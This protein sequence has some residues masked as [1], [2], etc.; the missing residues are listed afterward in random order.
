MK[1]LIINEQHTQN[2]I[3]YNNFET[4]FEF[5]PQRSLPPACAIPQFPPKSTPH[6]LG[7]K[8]TQTVGL[9]VMKPTG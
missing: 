2:F 6:M 5:E 3:L 9:H 7:S 8:S 4:N 1:S